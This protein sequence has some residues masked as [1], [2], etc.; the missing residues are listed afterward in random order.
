MR[1]L[2]RTMIH[3]DLI[4]HSLATSKQRIS[5]R[6]YGKAPLRPV[7]PLKGTGLFTL[8]ACVHATPYQQQAVRGQIVWRFW[9]AFERALRP[10][11]KNSGASLNSAHDCHHSLFRP[12]VKSA[13]LRWKRDRLG[14]T[15]TR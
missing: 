10:R 7:N 4:G 3:H 1:E 13:T 15:A 6:I 14:V 2:W 11:V 9:R 5:V 12:C 8:L